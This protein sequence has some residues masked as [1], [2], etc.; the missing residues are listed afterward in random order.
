MDIKTLE[1]LQKRVSD[2]N[3]FLNQIDKAGKKVNPSDLAKLKDEFKNVESEVQNIQIAK[4]V[5]YDID[6]IEKSLGKIER[7]LND[8]YNVEGH[9]KKLNEILEA[10]KELIDEV[11]TL[12]KDIEEFEEY[13]KDSNLDKSASLSSMLDKIASSLEDR[14]H[15]RE[16]EDLDVI[17]NTLEANVAKQRSNVIKT[18]N[19]T[20]TIKQLKRALGENPDAKRLLQEL[21]GKNG[22]EAFL[23]LLDKLGGTPDR[24]GFNLAKKYAIRLLKNDM[25][26]DSETMVKQAMDKK[27]VILAVLIALA[28]SIDTEVNDVEEIEYRDL[29]RLAKALSMGNSP[30]DMS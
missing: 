14:G 20:R 19:L 5:S 21:S 28:V 25:K 18:K 15:L 27:I 23:Y 24:S 13:S 12:G 7:G 6:Q 1:E 11:K 26:R 9:N 22:E 16:A 17:A 30:S 29:N 2:L 10:Y 4:F 3:K 8:T